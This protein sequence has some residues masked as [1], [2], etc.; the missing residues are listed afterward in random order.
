ML[1]QQNINIEKYTNVDHLPRIE[2]VLH[3]ILNIVTQPEVDFHQLA[4]KIS[5]DQTL[6]TKLLKLA[7]SAKYGGCRRIASLHDAIVRVGIEATRY[8]VRLSVLVQTFSNIDTL[9]MKDYWAET[10]EISML[11]SE[12]A[13]RVDL[14]F[15]E[16]FTAGTLH[17][18]GMLLVHVN[19]PGEA[20][21]IE[22]RVD[23]GDE[24]VDAQK[25]VIGTDFATIG[26]IF[27]EI[28]QFPPQM[29]DA[30]QHIDNPSEATIAPALAHLLRF[31]IDVHQRWDFMFDEEKIEFIESNP[32]AIQL[33]FDRKIVSYIDTFRG[34][35][36]NLA[37]NI[38][39]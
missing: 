21:E 6:S 12:L 24:P 20:L 4:I 8:I 18:I 38:F 9:N 27:A 11:A 25:S 10:F 39:S 16:V 7:N 36:Y 3:E 14:D 19:A 23:N 37:H 29:V 34:D 22:M 33:G 35:G 30:I 32:S 15:E 13:H 28:S 31:S 5:M 1:A 17:N 2:K 26:A